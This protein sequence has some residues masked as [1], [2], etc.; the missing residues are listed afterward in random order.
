MPPEVKER[1]AFRQDGLV[2]YRAGFSD[3]PSSLGYPQNFSRDV[4]E[5]AK[6]ARDSTMAR[7]QLIYGNLHQA[8]EANPLNGAEPWKYHHQLPGVVVNEELESS[9]CSTDATANYFIVHAFYQQETGDDSLTRRFKYNLQGAAE[10]YVASHI[11]PVTYQF[12]E[13]PKHCGAKSFAL[14]RTDWKDS[15]M[16]G[17]GD[18]KGVPPVRYPLIQAQYMAGL[19]SLSWLFGT[20]EFANEA[21]KMRRGLQALF[22]KEL[23]CFYI[24][25]DRLGPIQGVSSDG[26]NMLIYLEE[27]DITF[28]QLENIIL[29]AMVLETQAGFLNLDPQIAQTMTDDYHTRVWPKEQANIHDGARKWKKIVEREGP[30]YLLEYLDYVLEVSSRVVRFLDSHPETL[31]VQNGSVEK[32]GCDPALWTTTA[33]QY[34]RSVLHSTSKAA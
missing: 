30:A 28:E 6:T 33:K 23:G 34:F 25:Q 15:M 11:N 26:L 10:V 9:Y 7:D 27:G 1:L 4:L 14:K 32:A 12:E 21:E 3:D 29:S 2:L 13:D 17:R 22:D 19:R 20:D 16:P 8:K 18:G 31:K 5:G 24:A